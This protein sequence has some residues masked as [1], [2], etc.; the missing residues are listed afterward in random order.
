MATVSTQTESTNNVPSP[1]ELPLVGNAFDLVFDGLGQRLKWSREFGDIYRLNLAGQHTIVIA[2]PD[3]VQEVL[4]GKPLEFERSDLLNPRENPLLGRGL[5]TTLNREFR[6]KRKRM[7]PAFNHSRVAEYAKIMA[8]YAEEQAAG[9]RDGVFDIHHE[10]MQ[11]TMQIIGKTMFDRDL[12]GEADEL[13]ETI[14]RLIAE[15]NNPLPIPPE[16]PTPRNIR[17]RKAISRLDATVY[18]MIAERKADGRDHG[19]LLSML[20]TSRDEAGNAMSD[21][22]VRDELMTILIAGHETTALALTW[23]LHL[24]TQHPGYYERVQAEL[25]RVLVGRTPTVA[26]LPQLSYTQQAIKEAL[27]LYPPAH[28]IARANEQAE[29]LGGYHIPARTLLLID[30][31][32]MHR[33]ADYFAQPEQYDPDRFSPER[34]KQLARGA[35]LPFGTGPRICIGQAFAMMEAQMV[36]ATLMQRVRF[37]AVA[38]W[39]QPDA[40]VTLRPK[41]GLRMRVEQQQS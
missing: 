24:L 23:T 11:V 19:D 15:P 28:V 25:D 2:R 21:K 31:W 30:V 41:G 16:W 29:V 14:T 12:S 10:M 13:G 37:S 3:W 20:L 17:V 26:D 33:R 38:Q 34:E 32:A 5:F 18:Q 22:D 9:W 1:R 8:E 36:L 39:V 6:P 35:Y 27:R 40:V 4:M 7:Q